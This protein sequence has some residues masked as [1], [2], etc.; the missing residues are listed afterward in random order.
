[1]PGIEHY[2]NLV[3]GAGTAGKVF[4]WTLAKQGEP[5]AVVERR[6]IGGA[7]PNIAC[8]PSKN[9]IQ[10]AKV[11]SLLARAA[12]FGIETQPFTIRMEGV[13][14]RKRRMV[15]GNVQKHLKNF[16]ESGAELILGEARLAGPRTLEVK[17]NDGGTRRVSADRLFLNL[18]THAMIPEIPGLAA[19][20]PMTHIEALE[21][22][23]LPDDLVIL[24]G[25]YVGVEFAQAMRR[26][27]S[28]VT[29]I[30][31]GRQLLS[32]EDAD[33]GEAMLQLFRDEGIDVLLNTD[34]TKVDGTSG[35]NIRLQVKQE[36]RE[37]TLDATDILVVTGRIPNTSGIGLEEAGVQL[38]GRGYISVNDRLETTAMGVWAVGEC[39]GS[40]QFTHVSYD[41]FAIVHD[42]LNS[43]SRTTRGRLVPYCIFTDPEL[44]R[45]G[46]NESEARQRRIPY[47]VIRMPASDV[48]RAI[49][50]SET[51]GFLKMLI[52]ENGNQILGF[53]A[54][55]A[56]ADD[57]MAVVQTAMLNRMPFPDLR[58]AIFT[59]PTM[60][61]ALTL[62][63]ANV[64]VRE[65][66]RVG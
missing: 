26:F 20:K 32:R 52:E 54:F 56:G 37:R 62:M 29:V 51:R 19:A 66:V 61:E 34:L 63:L 53:T 1:M 46:L 17:L 13:R 65:Y 45:V 39:A 49:T 60:A 58:D 18:G 6:W 38:D 41:D 47:R 64:E 7:C 22:G 55:I 43:R 31:R 11:A 16:A 27:G 36:G 9:V 25:G 15:E 33:V 30:V 35:S 44:A 2:T 23:R 42:N 24:G 28:R 12:E 10:S 3:L 57:L 8:M 50:I 48:L 14:D 21:L 4:G 59:H 5:T 40:P